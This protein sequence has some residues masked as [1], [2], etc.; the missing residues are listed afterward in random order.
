MKLANLLAF[1]AAL[2]LAAGD[3]SAQKAKG[4]R[5][6]APVAAKPAVAEAAPLAYAGATVHT[7]TGEVLTDATVVVA[8]GK[9]VSVGKGAAPAGAQTIDARG[10]V[11]TPGLVDA[12]TSVGLVEVELEEATH[13]D[14][15]AGADLLH[16]GFRAA[17]ILAA[18][19]VARDFKLRP[20]IAGGAEGWKVARELA[21]AKVPVLVYPLEQPSSFDAL[22]AREDNAARLHA[23]GVPVGIS[24]GSTHN[25]RKLRQVAGNAVRGGLPHAAAIAAITRVP[26]E[27]LGLGA[28]YGTLAAGKVANLA[29]WSG[30]PL[31]LSTRVVDLVIRG[32][33]VSL[34]SRQTVLFEKYRTLAR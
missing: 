20:V 2:A 16:A 12:L 8:Q 32:R 11:I 33:R 17:D 7:G 29:V 22:G 10:M 27:A 31:E 14:H 28:R 30:D 18:L 3:A 25:A 23:A 6:A 15:Q 13:D 21:A 1:S 9:I 34:R 26:A 4:P 24:T 5:A 19:G